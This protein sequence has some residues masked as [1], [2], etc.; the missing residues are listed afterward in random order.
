M[1]VTKEKI[2]GFIGSKAQGGFTLLEAI[3]ASGLSALILVT[4]YIALGQGVDVARDVVRQQ[5]ADRSINNTLIRFSEDIASAV[6][7]WGGTTTDENGDTILD[8][9]PNPREVTFVI[10]R[11]DKSLAWVKYELVPGILT[12]DTY[13]VRLSDYEDPTEM[14][15]S[16][17]AQNVANL[18][19]VYYDEDGYETDD[20]TEVSAVEMVLI[21][22]TGI[23]TKQGEI[24]VR[25]R[26]ENQGLMIPFYDFESERDSQILK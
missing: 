5:D 2:H 3:I 11:T 24:F 19:L 15:L 9:T 4:L 13:L 16:Y 12:D 25:L 26:N 10:R 14:R 20:L 18:L 22:D 17:I 23:A 1:F 21:I 6:Y 8:S 7:F